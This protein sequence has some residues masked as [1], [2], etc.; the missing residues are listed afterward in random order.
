MPNGDEWGHEQSYKMELQER[1]N[2]HIREMAELEGY[3]DR[4]LAHIEADE[5][6]CRFL[7]KLGYGKLVEAWI[8]IPKWYA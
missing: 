5:I 6:L 4:E 8:K 1:C 3:H 2:E 7:R